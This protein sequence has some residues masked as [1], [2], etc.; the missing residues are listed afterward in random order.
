MAVRISSCSAYGPQ[1]SSPGAPDMPCRSVRTVLPAI[2][3]VDMVKNFSCSSGPPF[4]F[5]MMAQA[6]GPWI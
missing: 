3:M 1:I 6:F 5:S 4:S 2:L